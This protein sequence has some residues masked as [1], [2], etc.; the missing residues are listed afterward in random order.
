M[1]S[2]TSGN[3]NK[4]TLFGY[5]RSHRVPQHQQQEEQNAKRSQYRCRRPPTTGGGIEGDSRAAYQT[6]WT[7]AQQYAEFGNAHLDVRVYP[8][9]VSRTGPSGGLPVA[10]ALVSLGIGQPVPYGIGMSGVIGADGAISAIG[11]TFEKVSAAKEA[12]LTTVILPRANEND[13]DMVLF[14][15]HFE[16]IVFHYVSHFNEVHALLFGDP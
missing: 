2:S 4:S 16:E 6:A 10:A 13:I 1:Y 11:G 7:V 14:G 15:E 8:N 3:S 9:S 12:G 5:P